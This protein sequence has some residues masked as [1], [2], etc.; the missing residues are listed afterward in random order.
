MVGM[1][2][3][4]KRMPIRLVLERKKPPG[5]VAFPRFSKPASFWT[6]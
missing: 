2:G 5:K 1:C 6:R 4:V 3:S